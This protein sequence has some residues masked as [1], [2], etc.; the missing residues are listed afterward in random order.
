MARLKLIH[1]YR[2]GYGRGVPYTL[3]FFIANAGESA[4]DIAGGTPSQDLRADKRHVGSI[5]TFSTKLV[6][7]HGETICD[8]CAKQEAIGAMSEAQLPL[9]L[10]LVHRAQD[11]SIEFNS[12]DPGSVAAYLS[13]NLTWVAINV[14]L[15]TCD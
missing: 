14:S 11:S 15:L 6:D 13:E 4:I 10:E 2:Y 7:E 3:H 9:T 5:S 12:V 1:A 8:N